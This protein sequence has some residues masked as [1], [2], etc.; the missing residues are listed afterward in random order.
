MLDPRVQSGL[1]PAGREALRQAL[2]QALHGAFVLGLVL[3]ILG[4]AIVVLFMPAGGITRHA[5]ALSVA[6]RPGP[7]GRVAHQSEGG[8]RAG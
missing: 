2:A 1:T 7:A 3:V 6:D 5:P 8:G 4:L